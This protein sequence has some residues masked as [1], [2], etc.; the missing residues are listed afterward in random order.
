MREM[1]HWEGNLGR[2]PHHQGGLLVHMEAKHE[3]RHVGEGSGMEELGP[4]GPRPEA[5]K[6][7]SLK[8]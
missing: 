4:V 3:R 2:D 1:R 7:R 6:R 5:P 8:Q